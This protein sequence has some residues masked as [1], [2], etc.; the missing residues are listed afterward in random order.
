MRDYEK[1]TSLR[2]AYIRQRLDEAKAK[3]IVLGLSGGKDSAL[4]AVLCRMACENTIGIMLPCESTRNFTIDKND[5][6]ELA[7]KFDIKTELIDITPIKEKFREVYSAQFDI[8]PMASA[9]IN[10]RLRMI[11]LYTY[12]QSHNMLVCGTG[13]KS[14]GYMGYFTKWGDGAYDFN[15]IG[16][17]CVTEIYEFM[18]YL[19]LP[20][21]VIDKAPSAALFE[22][23]T[24]EGEMG[25]TY[26]EIEI[27]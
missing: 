24:D 9:N 16:D 14:E 23:Q 17:L 27:N 15:P 21:S 6:C 1:E 18:E 8:V 7:E 19:K 11:T 26:K 3:G 20:R 13:N 22:G 12:A 25:V 4:A 10:P 2:V 5:A